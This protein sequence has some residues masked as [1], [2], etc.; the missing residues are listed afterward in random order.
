MLI[1][2][3]VLTWYFNNKKQQKMSGKNVEKVEITAPINERDVNEGGK[4]LLCTKQMKNETVV[5]TTGYVYC[6]DCISDYV[7][8]EGK[9]PMSQARISLEH[10]QILYN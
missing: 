4:C 10:L 3:K 7:R 9:C 6:Y 1:G 2:H 5:K 8:R